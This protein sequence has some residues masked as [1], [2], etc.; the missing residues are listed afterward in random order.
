M[1]RTW[2]TFS[3]PT[4]YNDSFEIESGRRCGRNVW[5]ILRAAI[6]NGIPFRPFTGICTTNPNF[7]IK[8]IKHLTAAAQGL[9]F[10]LCSQCNGKNKLSTGL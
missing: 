7:K 9:V 2:A 6:R 10:N 5:S 3:W 1:L 8:C 4:L